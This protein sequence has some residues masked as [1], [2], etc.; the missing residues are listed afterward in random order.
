MQTFYQNN[1]HSWNTF[2]ERTD[3][4]AELGKID[5]YLKNTKYFPDE[6]NIFRFA[7]NDK[8]KIKVVIMGMEPYPSSFISGKK[9]YPVA[10]GRSFEIANIH[11]WSERFKQSSLRNIIKAIYYNE[12]GRYVSLETLR[13]EISTGNFLLAKPKQWFDCLESQGVSFLNASLTVQPHKVKTHTKLWEYFI[14]ELIKEIDKQNVVWMLWGREA[15]ERVLPLID[16]NKA[17][18]C[19][20]PRLAQ[21]VKENPFSKVKNIN[22]LGS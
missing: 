10:T 5:D 13:N 17:I 20:H 1:H 15:Q 6:E 18:C 12:T 8:T 19:C 22:W 2:F 9:T 14:S 16:K 7:K 3:I 4:Q 21:F 11:S